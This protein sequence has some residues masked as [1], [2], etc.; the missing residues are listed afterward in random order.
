VLGGVRA[1]DELLTDPPRPD[2]Q[3]DAIDTTRLGRFARRLWDGLLAVEEV[4]TR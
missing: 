2:E 3:W 1:F 4:T